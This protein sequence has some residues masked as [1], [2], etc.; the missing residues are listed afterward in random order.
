[1]GDTSGS[2]P[3]T[4]RELIDIFDDR[5]IHLGVVDRATVHRDGYWHQVFHLLI[6]AQRSSGPVVILQRRA[7]GKVSF[8]GLLDLSAT[9]HLEAG[10]RPVDG[11]RELREELG[12]DIDP[13][14][15]VA[16]GV[17]RMVDT[18]PEGINREF[19]HVFLALDDRPLEAYAPDHREVSAVVE[20]AVEAAL[21]LFVG[22]V[23][24]IDAVEVASETGAPR[25][26]EI[27][28]AQFVPEPSLGDLSLDAVA[29][30]YWTTILTMAQRLAAGETRLSI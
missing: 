24:A 21:D 2:E 16:L 26:V 25:A 29:S 4:T 15:L 20:V 12:I 9:G 5:G 7:D 10:E 30:P 18:T 11:V 14:E 22:R 8:P 3:V 17:R 1:M 6:V 13:T 28:T 23:L 27:S 19:C